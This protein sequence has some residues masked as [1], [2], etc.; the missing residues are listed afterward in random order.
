VLLIGGAEGATERPQRIRWP[1]VGTY[2]G[3]STPGNGYFDL[4]DT[5]GAILAGKKFAQFYVVY[6]T[7][8]VSVMQYI[9]GTSI[10]TANTIVSGTGIIAEKA[11]L[12]V[13][14][15]H[16][17]LGSDGGGYLDIFEFS[18]TNVLK[19]VG[20]PVGDLLKKVQ[21][22]YMARSFAVKYGSKCCFA[23]PIDSEYPD[24]WLVYDE[25]NK[26][27]STEKRTAV[28]ASLYLHTQVLTIGS[29]LG[30]IGDLQGLIGDL[31][32]FAKSPQILLGDLDKVIYCCDAQYTQVRGGSIESIYESGDIIFLDSK[33][34]WETYRLRGFD[35]YCRGAGSLE[36]QY[37]LDNG[38]TWLLPVTASQT[39]ESSRQWLKFDIDVLTNIVRFKLTHTGGS[40]QIQGG[41]IRRLPEVVVSGA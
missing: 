10:F 7:D 40:I 11:L 4:L 23:V 8:S 17:F 18:G 26:N 28:C 21:R 25:E 27:W 15:T 16:W 39:V 6:K 36:L 13:T 2:D 20:A 9:G 35:F 22:D 37:S 31:G 14:G 30:T 24:T 38:E 5:P 12:E 29:L 41:N 1:A 34:N 3:F 19:R 32:L 33:G